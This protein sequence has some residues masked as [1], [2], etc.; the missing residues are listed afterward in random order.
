MVSDTRLRE[1]KTGREALLIA[2]RCQASFTP[3]YHSRSQH[4]YKFL[5]T[6]V[7]NQ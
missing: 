2:E 1:N 6:T 5:A 7:A 3:L 4:G